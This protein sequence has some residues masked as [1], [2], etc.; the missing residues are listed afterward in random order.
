MTFVME[1]RGK[2]GYFYYKARFLEMCNFMV[3]LSNLRC[4]N[5]AR[6]LID[7]EEI[8]RSLGELLSD[9]L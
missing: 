6:R 8:K 5:S 2:D 3:G 1:L 4:A 9:V 7:L